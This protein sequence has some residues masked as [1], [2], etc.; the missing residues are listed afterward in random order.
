MLY[1][2]PQMTTISSQ[3]LWR[4]GRFLLSVGA[5]GPGQMHPCLVDIGPH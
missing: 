4:R 5:G 3:M 1:N 2:I